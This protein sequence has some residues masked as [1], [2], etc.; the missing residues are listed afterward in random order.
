MQ[1]SNTP[2]YQALRRLALLILLTSTIAAATGA[3]NVQRALPIE[4]RVKALEEARRDQQ[5]RNEAQDDLN[6]R[7]VKA[8]ERLSNA[9]PNSN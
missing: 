9:R 6:D 8:L 5:K 3:L 4:E 2:S 7:F 1:E